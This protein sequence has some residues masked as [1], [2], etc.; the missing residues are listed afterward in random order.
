MLLLIVAN[1][2]LLSSL[3]PMKSFAAL[4]L[5]PLTLAPNAFGTG[6]PLPPPGMPPSVHEQRAEHGQK[7][8]GSDRTITWKAWQKMP[9]G[10]YRVR[11]GDRYLGHGKWQ[12]YLA[13][14]QSPAC[15]KRIKFLLIRLAS[16]PVADVETSPG[17]RYAIVSITNGVMTARKGLW[18]WTVQ[19]VAREPWSS[20]RH[21]PSNF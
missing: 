13:F 14:E 4:M 16:E 9:G 20:A 12:H 17:S 18:S 5:V 7:V 2:L 3:I 21:V 6:I 1:T 10:D 11:T 19:E 15:M 8:E